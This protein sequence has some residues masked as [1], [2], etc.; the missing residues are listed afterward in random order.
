MSEELKFCSN[1]ARLIGVRAM[2]YDTSNWK[3][4]H[5]ANIQDEGIDLVTGLPVKT[6]RVKSIHDLRKAPIVVGSQWCGPEGKWYEEYV[7]P[8]RTAPDMTEAPKPATK[9]P[10]ARFSADEL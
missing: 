10:G 7:P 3:C 5:P 1:C 2:T 9:K 4:G 6:F 8:V